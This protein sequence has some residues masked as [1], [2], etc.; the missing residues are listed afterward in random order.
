MLLV[1]NTRSRMLFIQEAK[2]DCHH[3]I[4]FIRSQ[5]QFILNSTSNES[6]MKQFI[7]IVALAVGLASAD[8]LL[9]KAHMSNPH[10]RRGSLDEWAPAG[11]NDCT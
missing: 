6:K 3:P 4:F 9:A 8:P 10:I 11:P 1:I 5:N 7:A 2:A